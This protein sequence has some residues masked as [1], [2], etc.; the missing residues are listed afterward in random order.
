MTQFGEKISEDRDF[1][2]A[3]GAFVLATFAMA[4]MVGDLIWFVPGIYFMTWLH[5]IPGLLALTFIFYAV[6]AIGS[7]QP[8]ETLRASIRSFVSLRLSG[9]VLFT[10]IAIFHGA[11]TSMKSMLPELHPFAFDPVLAS[12]DEALH[13]GQAWMHLQ[14][15]DGVTEIV[16]FLYRQ[17]W[18]F[19]V[20]AVTFAVCLSRTSHLRSQ[21]I[22]TF[23]FCWIG[24]GIIVA[25]CVMSAGP[26]YYDRLLDSDRFAALTTRL[27][28]LRTPD[29]PATLYA[30]LLWEAYSSK[31][32]GIA[33][34]ISA[35]PSLHLAMAT[36][37]VLT[38]FRIRPALGWVMMGYLVITMIG[39]VHLGWHYAVDGYAAIIATTVAWVMIGKW[40]KRPDRAATH[41]APWQR[42]LS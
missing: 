4:V 3:I 9:L 37:F 5:V 13:G 12:L 40:L 35:F 30:D 28:S 17:V 11:F 20:T 18:F 10:C 24:L 39:S 6:R 36:L 21:Y 15:L 14:L 42:A 27:Q 7:P 33:T 32:P 26:I 19:L 8:I 25:S 2:M 22:W 34:G 16:R 31:A 38:G 29:I 1:Y 23:L 41:P